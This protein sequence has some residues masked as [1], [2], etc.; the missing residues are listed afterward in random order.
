[1]K[2]RMEEDSSVEQ[3]QQRTLLDQ[4]VAQDHVEFVKSVRKQL[5]QAEVFQR[6][7]EVLRQLATEKAEHGKE[8]AMELLG[9]AASESIKAERILE[10]CEWDEWEA[11]GRV[12]RAHL[13]PPDMASKTLHRQLAPMLLK[14]KS[15]WSRQIV[16]NALNQAALLV[17]PKLVSLLTTLLYRLSD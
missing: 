15:D 13:P 14:P 6:A 7:S 17:L 8:V 4:L 16:K 12:I 2:R 9:L 10:Q 5:D 11:V 3:K 1:M